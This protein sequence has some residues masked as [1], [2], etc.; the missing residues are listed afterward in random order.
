MWTAWLDVTEEGVRFLWGVLSDDERGR[1]ARFV[2]SEDQRKFV[3]ARGA[4]RRL[5]GLYLGKNPAAVRLGYSERGKPFVEDGAGI[6]FNLSHSGELAL[7]A[8]AS[9]RR[10]G[11]DV[12]KTR[13]GPDRERGST[14]LLGVRMDRP[15]DSRR[16][17]APRGTP[18]VLGSKGSL[19]QGAR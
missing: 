16:N 17:T 3:V 7:Y 18:R 4:L 2:R 13:P 6:T 9:A 11:I 8:I 1:A 14:A 5:L 10:V 19:R 15:S 12:E